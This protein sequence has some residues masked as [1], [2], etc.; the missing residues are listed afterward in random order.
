MVEILVS[1]KNYFN[2]ESFKEMCLFL[3]QGLKVQVSISCIGHGRNNA[4]QENYRRAF[5]KKYGRKVNIEVIEGAYSYSYKYSLKG[6][7]KNE[8][9]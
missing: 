4:E 3:E 5:V 2:E 9:N 6:V 1:G 8:N 7:E